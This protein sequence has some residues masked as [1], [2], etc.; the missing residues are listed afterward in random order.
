MQKYR[1][2][3]SCGPT[4]LNILR[5]E[6]VKLSHLAYLTALIWG[7]S[8]WGTPP[9]DPDLGWHLYGGA[10]VLQ[11]GDVPRADSINAFN[12]IWHDYHWLGQV[13][14]YLVYEWGGFLALSLLLAVLMA[15]FFCVL[16]RTALL[17]SKDFVW[18]GIVSAAAFIL[19]F[20]VASIRPQV[21]ALLLLA[22]LQPLVR[23]PTLSTL[24]CCL[25]GTVILVNVHVY[26]LFIPVLWGAYCVLPRILGEAGARSAL[27]TWGG[28]ALLFL[29]PLVSP[30]G[31]WSQE[32][33]QNYFIILEYLDMPSVLRET[34]L[35]F[36]SGL[37]LGNVQSL[38]LLA[39]AGV[40]A[41]FT[42]R[43]VLK[44]H[45]GD[46][47]CATL[48]FALALL[49]S[50]YLGLF[51][52]LSLPF[53]AALPVS[54]EFLNQRRQR[55]LA[56]LCLA[57]GITFA[58]WRLPEP[59]NTRAVI[60]SMEPYTLCAKLAAIPVKKDPERAHVRILTHF[61]HGGWCKFALWE[62]NP[63]L[64]YRVT[65]DNRTQGVPAYHYEDS[66]DLF[67]VRGNWID[68]LRNW[69]PEL[70]VVWKRFP[71]A[72]FLAL[73]T[74]RWEKVLEDEKFVAFRRIEAR[75]E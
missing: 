48:S 26:W 49:G 36:R 59:E 38:L 65:T 7:L 23:R 8:F 4:A 22:V 37:A 29:A 14:L 42:T 45:C 20:E 61:N 16:L 30:Y 28:L 1:R 57:G 27:F 19:L 24:V 53:F 15:A 18:A 69:S 72:S 44:R 40:A 68:T 74:Q 10:W 17:Q 2:Y 11:H 33:L 31:F 51:A 70:A 43:D 60:D 6:H 13:G 12:L 25:L 34:I 58:C 52:V 73:D 56:L 55:K 64:P 3:S 35:E 66:F 41:R 63:G 9:F 39:Y 32:P 21:F 71:L 75:P 50:K 62:T 47:A 67:G 46:F 5:T 54:F